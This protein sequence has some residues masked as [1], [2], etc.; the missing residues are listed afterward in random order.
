MSKTY[1]QVRDETTDAL[2]DTGSI[3]DAVAVER[4]AQ[5]ER[6]GEQN[7]PVLRENGPITRKAYEMTG[8]S[9]KALNDFLAEDGGLAWDGILLEEV[10]E[11]LSEEDPAKRRVE[12][13]Q[14]MAV[15]A[16]MIQCED[17]RAG[18]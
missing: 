13:I 7:R 3:F 12:L 18:K 8:E 5:D 11:A 16:A 1:K 4:K 2:W 17:R 9:W 15:A 6:F 10:Y 14:V